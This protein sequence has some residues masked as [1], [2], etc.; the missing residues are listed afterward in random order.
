MQ[1]RKTGPLA[2]SNG[3]RASCRRTRSASA[4]RRPGVTDERSMLR[5]GTSVGVDVLLPIGERRAERLVAAH[6]LAQAASQRVP[7]ER[8]LEAKDHRD[9]VV[10][11]AGVE[12]IEEP[13][14]LLGERQGLRPGPRMGGERRHR[15]VGA[16]RARRLHPAREPR[17]GGRLEERADRQLDPERAADPGRDA[18]REQELAAEIEE[19]VVDADGPAEQLAPGGRQR[20]LGARPRGTNVRSRGAVSGA[21]RALR[22]SLPLGVRGRAS[23]RTKADGTM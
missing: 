6:H 18:R 21:G 10:R 11:P 19:V 8:S 4:S 12:A 17:D 22:S 5:T 20:L 15:D 3:L 1:A 14:A 23:R 7:V 13:Q 16:L 2:R 9:V